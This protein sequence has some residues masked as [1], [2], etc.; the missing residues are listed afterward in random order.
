[1]NEY[2]SGIMSNNPYMRM[3]EEMKQRKE[4]QD[5]QQET[6]TQDMQKYGQGQMQTQGQDE[7][8]VGESVVGPM[9]KYSTTSNDEGAAA[10]KAMSS[11]GGMS[12]GQMAEAAGQMM[13]DKKTT[14]PP[15]QLQ[16][17]QSSAV[18]IPQ[19]VPLQGQQQQGLMQ[20]QSS[21]PQIDRPWLM[22]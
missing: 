9:S 21:I 20:S 3:F 13:G 15:A 14:T 12:W 10:G 5:Q 6:F 11:G 1:M 4:M 17:I 7:I 16:D 8:S 2:F 19:L 18:S 22:G